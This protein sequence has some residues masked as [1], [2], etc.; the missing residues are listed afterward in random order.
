MHFQI[1]AA[2][3]GREVVRGRIQ[4]SIFGH[5]FRGYEIR[6]VEILSKVKL[7]HPE[8]GA[9]GRMEEQSMANAI[10]GCDLSAART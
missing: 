5:V 4:L 2:R 9:A 3:M 1:L 6:F 10:I 8:G 7:L